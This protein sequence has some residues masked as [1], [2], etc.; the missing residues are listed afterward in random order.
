MEGSK[1]AMVASAPLTFFRRDFIKGEILSKF[2]SQSYKS[3][4]TFVEYFGCM[5]TVTGIDNAVL[6][7]SNIMKLLVVGIL[8]MYICMIQW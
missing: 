4:V 1:Q 6:Y 2:H 3:L 8:L 7:Y 5:K